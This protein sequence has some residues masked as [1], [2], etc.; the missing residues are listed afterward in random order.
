MNK[1]KLVIRA[2]AMLLLVLC[3]CN[4]V[5]AERT[6]DEKVDDLVRTNKSIR[7]WVSKI[8]DSLSNLDI[9]MST[10]MNNLKYYIRDALI[11]YLLMIND[12]VLEVFVNP[13]AAVT[14]KILVETI[15]LREIPMLH[16]IWKACFGISFFILLVLTLIGYSFGSFPAFKYDNFGTPDDIMIRLFFTLAL[17]TASKDL[18]IELFNLAGLMTSH[19]FDGVSLQILS[20]WDIL[21]LDGLIRLVLY[22]IF[23]IPAIMSHLIIFIIVIIRYLDVLLMTCISPICFSTFVLPNTSYIAKNHLKEYTSVLLVTFVLM[24]FLSLYTGLSTLTGG[25][26]LQFTNDFEMKQVAQV[27]GQGIMMIVL[28]FYVVTRPAWIK[29]LL[30]VSSA[31]SIGQLIQLAMMFL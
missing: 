6:T 22:L 29:R 19:V 25:M 9:N 18:C 27:V 28:V 15:D 8:F 23:L 1:R 12:T 10:L 5:H 2:I 20:S 17:M 13:L 26:I 3:I 24:I 16:T 11:D 30:G 21:E 31:N 4:I 7:E 14:P